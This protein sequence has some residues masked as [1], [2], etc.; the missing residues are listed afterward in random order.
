MICIMVASFSVL[1]LYNSDANTFLCHEKYSRSPSSPTPVDLCV[2]GFHFSHVFPNFWCLSFWHSPVHCSCE[3]S[4]SIRVS[5]DYIVSCKLRKKLH[6]LLS[7][8][9]CCTT[10]L[11]TLVVWLQSLLG[12]SYIPFEVQIQHL[13]S[14]VPRPSPSFPSLAVR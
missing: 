11:A 12:S 9:A 13:V 3:A 7:E 10:L 2:G 8:L 5:V 4:H 1:A 6:I 14:L